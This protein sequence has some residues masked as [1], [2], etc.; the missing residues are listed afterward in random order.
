MRAAPMSLPLLE[1]RKERM[2]PHM[3]R[4]TATLLRWEHPSRLPFFLF[5]FSFPPPPPAKLEKA[6]CSF[7]VVFPL[8]RRPPHWC[9]QTVRGY[10]RGG[11][12]R[13]QKTV[14]QDERAFRWTSSVPLVYPR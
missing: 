4:H 13:E 8:N 11:S 2:G 10:G 5:L 1:Q 14:E 6:G 3:S 7:F 12:P 9:R